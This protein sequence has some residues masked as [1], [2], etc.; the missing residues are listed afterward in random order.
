L[1][2]TSDESSLEHRVVDISGIEH[3]D[4]SHAIQR[5]RL[6]SKIAAEKMVAASQSIIALMHEVDVAYAL[7]DIVLEEDREENVK[8]EELKDKV[9]ACLQKIEMHY[10]KSSEGL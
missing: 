8:I 2:I 1:D 5:H 3:D 4:I 7:N 10:N 6:N 9:A